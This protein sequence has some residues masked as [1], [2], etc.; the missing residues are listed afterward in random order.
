MLRENAFAKKR[1]AALPASAL[2][3]IVAKSR[4]SLFLT[5]YL[6]LYPAF[7]VAHLSY[8][9][10]LRLKTVGYGMAE[11]QRPSLGNIPLC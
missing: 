3:D 10:Q 2:P 5:P 4:L 6:L 8:D 7:L 9:L 11:P 1:L